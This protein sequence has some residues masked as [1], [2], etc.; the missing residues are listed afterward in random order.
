MRTF[1]DSTAAFDAAE[2]IG[3]V[4]RQEW[5][6]GSAEIQSATLACSQARVALTGYDGARRYR[7]SGL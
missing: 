5:A 4:Q 7:A 2:L 6:H 1:P 3:S